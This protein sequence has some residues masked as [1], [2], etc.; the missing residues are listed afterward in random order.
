MRTWWSSFVRIFCAF[1]NT[2]INISKPQ[3]K[4]LNFIIFCY[5]C[6]CRCCCFHSKS[7]RL[8]YQTLDSSAVNMIVA[9]ISTTF[10]RTIEERILSFSSSLR[11]YSCCFL[12]FFLSLYRTWCRCHFCCAWVFQGIL[13]AIHFVTTARSKQITQWLARGFHYLFFLLRS[14]SNRHQPARTQYP[15]IYPIYSLLI[16]C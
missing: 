7:M 15:H 12:F 14:H 9:T 16:L 2:Q 8:W 10:S 11:L 1:G 5:S 4:E 3:H 6:Q 13:P